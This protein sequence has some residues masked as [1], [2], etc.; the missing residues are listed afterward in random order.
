MKKFLPVCFVVVVLFL[1]LFPFVTGNMEKEELNPNTRAH[2]KGNF[3]HLSDG[4]THYELRGEDHAQTII[5]V[6]GN[7]APYF[8]WDYN[9]DALVNSGFRV[10]RYDIYGHGYSDRPDIPEYNRDLY[11]RQLFELIEKLGI[12]TPVYLAGTSQGGSICAYFV[13]KHP[14]KVGKVAFLSPL[15][16][17]FTAPKM[18]MRLMKMKGVGEYLMSIVGDAMLTNPSP[19]LYSNAKKEEL[20]EK[21]QQQSR[22]KGKK[23]AV[24]ANLRGDGLDDGT[25]YYEQV[26][27]QNIPVLLTW[28]ENDKTIPGDSM[29]R[30]C[31][32]IPTIHYH[33]IKNASH[34]VHYES[35][36][37]INSVLIDF[38]NKN[39]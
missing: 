37:K 3:I 30:L 35:W 16:D 19:K 21:L 10:L 39:D 9:I 15:F 5:L 32:L 17:S 27:Q 8:T 29:E 31:K 4:I 6:H 38:F 12:Q 33:E 18:M 22:F 24:L 13:A 25:V 28:G 20:V 7:A 26:G 36:E 2:L 23:R 11:N 34:L 1:T 14:G